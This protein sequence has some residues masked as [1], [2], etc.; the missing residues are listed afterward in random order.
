MAFLVYQ[1]ESDAGRRVLRPTGETFQ[2]A[3]FGLIYQ[4][5]RARRRPTNKGWRIDANELLHRHTQGRST[6]THALVVDFHPTATNR[7][8]LVELLEIYAFTWAYSSPREASWTP[9]MLR[10]RDLFYREYTR[11]LTEKK[12]SAI[13]DCVPEPR[14]APESI[15]FLYLNGDDKSWNWGRVGATNAAFLQ[16]EARDYFREFF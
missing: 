7:V 3:G 9:L 6:E 15:E 4:A 14:N 2:L 8:G 12:R 16:G 1:R 5:W 10:M 11:S 13:M